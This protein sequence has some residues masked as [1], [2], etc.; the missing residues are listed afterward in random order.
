MLRSNHLFVSAVLVGLAAL[1]TSCSIKEDM[2]D[3]SKQQVDV[4][5][6]AYDASGSLVTSLTLSDVPKKRNRVTTARGT[7]FNA[8]GSSSFTFEN[9]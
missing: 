1:L 5:V 8:G 9:S 4:V 7:L 2:G 6:N 3:C